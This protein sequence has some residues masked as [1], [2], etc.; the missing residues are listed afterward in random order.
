MTYF[1]LEVYYPIDRNSY[2]VK[3]INKH[4]L[5]TTLRCP[6]SLYWLILSICEQIYRHM[7]CILSANSNICNRHI[8]KRGEKRRLHEQKK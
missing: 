5:N 3:T 8:E 1:H 7:S 2:R 4:L 6:N